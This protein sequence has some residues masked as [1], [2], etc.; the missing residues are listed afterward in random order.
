MN[1]L[2]SRNEGNEG[3]VGFRLPGEAP[4]WWRGSVVQEASAD[5]FFLAPFD[6]DTSPV[7]LLPTYQS[8]EAPAAWPSLA[9]YPDR[10]EDDPVSYQQ[11]VSTAIAAIAQGDLEKVVLSRATTEKVSIDPIAF[12]KQL[13]ITYPEAFVYLLWTPQYG[14]WAGATP[15]TLLA[16]RNEAWYTQS[17]A[18]TLPYPPTRD[19]AEKEYREQQVVT[20]TI[21]ESLKMAGFEPF[22]GE[23]Q[24]VMAGNV[25]HLSTPILVR[26][27]YDRSTALQLAAQLHPTPAVCGWPRNK[28]LAAIQTIEARDRQLYAGYLG[29]VFAPSATQLFVNL[30][31]C[32]LWQDAATLHVGGGIVE[33]SEP[34]AEWEETEN[35][36]QT[37]RT[38]LQSIARP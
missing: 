9:V 23:Q 34:E 7:T 11:K 19:W 18:G 36:A 15:E 21:V 20:D 1:G 14:C 13:T 22:V 38:V 16:Y 33:G 30:R 2:W 5:G 3:V 24:T 4:V 31:C 35:K 17:L 32:Q 6:R 8:A 26:A 10:V 12:F 29:P 27:A 25:Q 28:A 37:L